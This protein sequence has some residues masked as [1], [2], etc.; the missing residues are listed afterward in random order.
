VGQF[1]E[2]IRRVGRIDLGLYGKS[3]L[4]EMLRPG[5][6]MSHF[7]PRACEGVCSIDRT[8]AVAR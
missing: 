1:D 2:R 7:Q 6:T 8:T 3:L 5:R 4:T